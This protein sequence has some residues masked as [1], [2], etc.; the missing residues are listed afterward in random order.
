MRLY[1]VTIFLSAFLLFQVQ[2]L[3]GKRILPWFG[4]GAGIWTA[5]L[6]FFQV[7]LL[8]GYAYAHGLSRVRVRWQMG[9]HEESDTRPSCPSH[10][11]LLL[12]PLS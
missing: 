2:P 4:G 1:A 11:A 7:F 3:L 8:V 9:A 10:I 6:M 12:Q 5:C